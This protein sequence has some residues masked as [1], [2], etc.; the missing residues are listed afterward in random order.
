MSTGP[1][2]DRGIPVLCAPVALV[3]GIWLVSTLAHWTIRGVSWIVAALSL[4]LAT[5]L[6]IYIAALISPHSRHGSR[7]NISG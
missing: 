6:L 1:S 5:S 7:P 2:A 3:A 4:F